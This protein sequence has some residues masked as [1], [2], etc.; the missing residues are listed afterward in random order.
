LYDLLGADVGELQIVAADERNG[1]VLEHGN[2]FDVN[3]L[4]G[5]IAL[6]RG[7]VKR[8][9]LNIGDVAHGQFDVRERGRRGQRGR[10]GRRGG[11]GRQR[12]RPDAG[13]QNESE[14]CEDEFF[15]S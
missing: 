13:G 4:F 7:H 2:E 5:E 8:R 14:K 12:R 6:L 3:A 11:R 9:E 1:V 15:H 10:G